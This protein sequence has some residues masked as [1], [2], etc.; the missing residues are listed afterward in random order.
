MH[1]LFYNWQ[2]VSFVYTNSTTNSTSDLMHH[3]MTWGYS[4]TQC[5]QLTGN[6]ILLYYYETSIMYVAHMFLFK[7]KKT[8]KN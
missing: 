6:F 5:H 2:C 7:K 4:V 3:D 8:K 1:V